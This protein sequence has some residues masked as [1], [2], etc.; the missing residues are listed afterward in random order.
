[1]LILTPFRA[2][3]TGSVESSAN[4]LIRVAVASWHPGFP[5]VSEV[6]KKSMQ[7]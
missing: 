3:K 5:K 4:E 1:M 2:T 7:K 6:R